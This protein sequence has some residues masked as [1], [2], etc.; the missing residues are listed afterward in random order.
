[1]IKE[2]IIIFR[3]KKPT[4]L[5]LGLLWFLGFKNQKTTF[6]KKETSTA[7]E[8]MHASE[9]YMHIFNYKGAS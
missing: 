7:V 4:N 8:Y 9:A 3:N 6:F 1:V 5:K 2:T